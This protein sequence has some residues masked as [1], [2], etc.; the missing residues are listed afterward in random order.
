MALSLIDHEV[1]ELHRVRKSVGSALVGWLLD[2]NFMLADKK[3]AQ[4]IYLDLLVCLLLFH[5]PHF[6]LPDLRVHYLK[7]DTV[8]RER[9][10][11]KLKL[12]THQ[13]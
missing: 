12:G 1:E 11:Y 7:P 13:G 4:L 8:S 10:C 6:S 5:K 9:L 2:S 3:M